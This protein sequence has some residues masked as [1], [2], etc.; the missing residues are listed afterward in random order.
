MSLN[1]LDIAFFFLINKGL[2]NGIFDL[3]MPF[4]TQRG[5]LLFMPFV[6]WAAYKEKKNALPYLILCLAALGIADGGGNV[7]KHIF[8]RP[9]PCT[10]LEGVNL[11][12]G[13][14]R[15]FSMPSNHALNSFAAACIFWPLRRKALNAALIGIAALIAFSR[16]YVGV[17]YPSDVVAG[18]VLGAGAAYVTH[19][20]YSWAL[21]I[22]EKRSYTEALWYLLLIVS[23][24]RIYHII[25]GPFDLS[26]DEAQ[27]WTWSQRPDWSYYSKGPMIAWLIYVSTHLFGNT[28]FGVRVWAVVFSALSSLI[29]FRLGRDMYDDRTGFGAAVLVQIVPLYAAFGMFFS[30]DSPYMF[31]WILSLFLFWQAQR[32]QGEA[33][34]GRE[35]L[36]LWVLLGLSTGCGLL[37]KYTMVL[38]F[39][40][41]VLYMLADRK[42]RRLLLSPGPYI[43]VLLSL[44]LFSPVVV[45]NAA[46]GCVSLKHTAGQ[47]HLG[48]GLRFSAIDLLEYIG[49]QFGVITPVLFVLLI[50]AVWKVRKE[51]NGAFL[52]WFSAPTLLFFGLKSIQGKVQGNWALAAYAAGFIAVSAYYLRDI[53]SADRKNK[54]TVVA[55]VLVALLVTALA[56]FPQ[57][58]PLPPEKHPMKKL[59]GSQELGR[60]MSDLHREMA[61]EGPVFILSDNYY[62]AS[63]LSFY[64]EGN[65]VTYCLRINRRM[66]QYDIWPG[67]AGLKGYNALFTGRKDSQT[68]DA[69]LKYFGEA[70][71]HCDKVEVSYESKLRNIMKLDVFK[72]YHFKGIEPG[73]LEM[74]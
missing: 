59:V 11:L 61:A 26:S 17:H 49:A 3:V 37:S 8:Q 71:D 12:V 52:F 30:I 22:R 48:D 38:F 57:V 1:E 35:A 9:R 32:L 33:G 29:L 73:P 56:H 43:T 72:C 7:L 36:G 60:K 25:T 21:S 40:S 68:H 54:R 4:V 64:M 2:H 53:E 23:L 28:E 14:G 55:A 31:F 18:A 46:H 65:P 5:I 41:G 47:A 39:L 20:L 63:L 16:V 51:G 27:Y 66:N 13:C 24:F 69:V 45:W 67:F 6:A 42:A 58:I 70:F 19:Q 62:Q 15:S 44:V 50:I 34:R 74:Y 10:V